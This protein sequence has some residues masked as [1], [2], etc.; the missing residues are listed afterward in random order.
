MEGQY[1]EHPNANELL[2][3]TIKTL[4][5]LS[6]NFLSGQKSYGITINFVGK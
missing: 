5:C 6:D 4:G 2:I 1:P 3:N